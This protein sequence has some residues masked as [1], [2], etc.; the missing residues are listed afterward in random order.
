MSEALQTA[1]ATRILA[2]MKTWGRAW[3]LVTVAVA[4]TAAGCGE[5][6]DGNTGGAD[7][8]GGND[9]GGSDAGG[10]GGASGGGGTTS[11]GGSGNSSGSGGEFSYGSGTVTADIDGVTVEFEAYQVWYIAQFDS[12][13]ISAN[14]SASDA[15]DGMSIEYIG[16]SVGTADCTNS[17][18]GQLGL[19][20]PREDGDPGSFQSQGQASCTITITEYGAV[21]EPIRGTFSG[22]VAGSGESKTITNG[23]FD[24][25]RGSD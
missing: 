7:S 25:I 6:D 16:G 10:S 22:V 2:H 9:S 18:E 3:G 21:G 15:A 17:A 12:L 8:G 24:V 23:S 19:Q 11:G 20:A 1:P 5:G 4:L 14:N 13:G